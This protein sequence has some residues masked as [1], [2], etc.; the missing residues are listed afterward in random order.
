LIEEYARTQNLADLRERAEAR[1]ADED[2]EMIESDD[3][4]IVPKGRKGKESIRAQVDILR[5]EMMGQSKEEVASSKRK[6]NA[7]LT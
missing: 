7:E 5:K 2:V 4:P 1:G 6:A 3:E